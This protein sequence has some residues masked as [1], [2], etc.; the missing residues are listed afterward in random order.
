MDEETIVFLYTILTVSVDGSVDLVAIQ[1]SKIV[2]FIRHLK[3][4]DQTFIP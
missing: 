4:E 1:L 3:T 2:N